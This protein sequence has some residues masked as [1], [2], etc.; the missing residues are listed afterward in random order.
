MVSE[1]PARAQRGAVSL[2]PLP[3]PQAALTPEELAEWLAW[4]GSKLL[5]MNLSD[6]SP[7]PPAIAWPAYAND[8]SAAYGYTG[9][10]LRPPRPTS[11]EIE[12]MDKILALPMLCRAVHVRKI[13][14]ARLL[15]TP[16]SNRHLYSW[17]KIAYVMHT[18]ARRVARLHRQGLNE[19]IGALA[20]EKAN[21]FR[22]LIASHTT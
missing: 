8:A 16:V 13:I 10:R 2:K 14:N 1:A 3:L 6:G 4:A 20:P 21:A 18:D 19:I 9:E 7:R 22:L 11:F 12:L 5:A 17:T 15:V